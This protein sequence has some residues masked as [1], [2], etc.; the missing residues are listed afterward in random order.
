L[1]VQ[2]LEHLA[3]HLREHI[4][5][6]LSWWDKAYE[7]GLQLINEDLRDI[8]E[9]KTTTYLEWMKEPYALESIDLDV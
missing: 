8:V 4:A 5:D 6:D 3:P 1:K 7:P 2:R 9:T